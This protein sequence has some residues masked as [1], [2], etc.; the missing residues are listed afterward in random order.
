M[1]GMVKWQPFAAV[2]DQKETLQQYYREQVKIEAP[3]ISQ[4]QKESN[5]QCVVD[6]IAQHC[7]VQVKYYRKGSLHLVEGYIKAIDTYQKQIQIQSIRIA[8]DELVEIQMR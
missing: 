1:R 4:D 5:E 2:F 3:L 8:F 6:A 7:I